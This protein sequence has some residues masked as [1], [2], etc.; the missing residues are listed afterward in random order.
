MAGSRVDVILNGSPFSGW[1]K[2]SVTQTF[3]NA[4][5]TAKLT[6]SPQ[7]GNPLPADVGDTA[8]VV[9]EGRPVITGHVHKVHA[10]HDDKTHDI[11]IELRDK[12]QDLIE[13]TTGPGLEFKP[14]V[15]LKKVAEDT[16]KKMG[17]SG[18]KVIDNA[19][20]DDYREYGEMPVGAIDQFGHDW[21][22]SWAKK[23]QVVLT[24][25]GK[26]NL[27]IDRNVMRALGGFLHKSFEDDPINNIQRASYENSD[28][29]RYNKHS[30]A[31]QKSTTDPSWEKQAKSYAPG[32][33][34]PVSKNI[35]EAVDSSVRPERRLYYRGE[36][37]VEG[38]TPEKAAKW[39]S[40][41]AR[42]RKY[43][44]SATVAGFTCQSGDL[45]WPGFV[46]PVHDDHFLI[47]DVMFIKEVEFH[48]EW[49]KGGTTVVKCTFKEAYS[50]KA[51]AGKSRTGKAGLG[52]KKTGS[53]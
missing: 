7:P 37:G 20:P 9:L 2:V 13:S 28:F 49:G 5:G 51:E 15:K 44:F 50:D 12:T 42:A 39:R 10:S 6:L 21:L 19:S 41:L 47:S 24:T 43:T 35:R 40:N 29:G 33:A 38:D 53:F 45:W 3:D 23:R 4:T 25:D 16:L 14:P 26:G 30:C 34:D 31:G 1:K 18:I 27:V 48:K 52:A 8:Q 36:V 17:L 32:Q 46:I 11:Q 22:D